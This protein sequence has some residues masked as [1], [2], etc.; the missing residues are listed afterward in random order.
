MSVASANLGEAS[1]SFF[2]G[3]V[4]DVPAT[5][6]GDPKTSRSRLTCIDSNAVSEG[7]TADVLALSKGDPKL[8]EW[9]RWRM[10]SDFPRVRLATELRMRRNLL[11]HN[12]NTFG[13]LTPLPK[14]ICAQIAKGRI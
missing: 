8:L 10:D 13:E 4:A 9:C 14:T 3:D 1:N 12:E 7:A 11:V 2:E 5:C 6:R